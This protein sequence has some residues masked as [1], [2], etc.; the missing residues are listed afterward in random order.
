MS[1]IVKCDGKHK[2]LTSAKRRRILAEA[3]ASRARRKSKVG[4]DYPATK[5]GDT[6]WIGADGAP[7]SVYYDPALGAGGLNVA[8]Y[9]L[10][11]LDLI[12]PYFDWCFGVKGK[13]GNVLI[14]QDIGGAYHYGCAFN[15]DGGGSDWYCSIGPGDLVAGLAAAEIC[16]SYMGLQGKGWDCG[17]SGGE[18]LSR[19]L[20]EVCTGGPDGAMKD[21]AT[22]PSWDGSD[23]L[24]QDQGTDTDYS[25][26]GCGVLYLWWMHSQLYTV[27]EIVQAGESDG[28]LAGNYASL[29]GKPA[30]QAFTD[31]Q[32]AM[33]SIG[34]PGSYDSDNPFGG[35]LP[36]FPQGGTSPPPPPPPPPPPAAGNVL[37]LST[38]LSAGSYPVGSSLPPCTAE[39]LAGYLGADLVGKLEDAGVSLTAANAAVLAALN[40]LFEC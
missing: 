11:Q 20:A 8:T 23:W 2:V 29:T 15:S 39:S 16:E 9:V 6:Q 19:F 28:T 3:V 34:P 13:A 31:F 26:I 1:G 27:D 17:G 37:T 4:F 40:V 21:Y 24:S 14:V 7:V 10:A 33:V 22:G 25:S 5:V 12:L 38:P 32:T 36:P 35:S 30:A 18:A